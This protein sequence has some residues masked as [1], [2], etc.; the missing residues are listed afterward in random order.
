MR[1]HDAVLGVV[2]T[3]GRSDVITGPGVSRTTQRERNKGHM[4]RSKDK[5]EFLSGGGGGLQLQ[6]MCIDKVTC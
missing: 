1:T 3:A 4:V 5:Q 6:E 2:A